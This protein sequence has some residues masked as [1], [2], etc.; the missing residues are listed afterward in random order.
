M[1]V[2][3][4][5][6]LTA[7]W[8]LQTENQVNSRSLRTWRRSAG[9][10]WENSIFSSS[11]MCSICSTPFPLTMNNINTKRLR[12]K[13][14]FSFSFRYSCMACLRYGVNS[15]PAATAAKRAQYKCI[16]RDFSNRLYGWERWVLS[17]HTNSVH[18]ITFV[19][20]KVVSTSTMHR[21]TIYEWTPYTKRRARN[22]KSLKRFWSANSAEKFLPSAEFWFFFCS[23][24]PS[25]RHIIIYL[26]RKNR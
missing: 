4:G 1:Y 5:I 19:R 3:S 25:V 8:P 24:G 15:S 14:M 26:P 13:Q 23:F 21:D 7:K 16:I 18:G 10:L 22:E 20:I 2:R 12:N 17:V 9:E 6:P 11:F